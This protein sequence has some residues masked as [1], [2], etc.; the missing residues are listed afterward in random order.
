M[1]RCASSSSPR[2]MVNWHLHVRLQLG[3]GTLGPV[4]VS[5]GD[6]FGAG[7]CGI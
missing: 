7:E 6:V 4:V 2:G 1:D 5:E 3:A